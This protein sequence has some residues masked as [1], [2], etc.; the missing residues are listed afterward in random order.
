MAPLNYNKIIE[1]LR[2]SLRIPENE[3]EICA[4]LQSLSWRIT[5]VQRSIRR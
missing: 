4:T 1:F 2:K 3:I 5:K